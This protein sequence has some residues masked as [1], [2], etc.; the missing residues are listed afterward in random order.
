[1]QET[2]NVQNTFPFGTFLELLDLA[3]ELGGWITR[4]LKLALL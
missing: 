4:G 1:M 2:F 3:S